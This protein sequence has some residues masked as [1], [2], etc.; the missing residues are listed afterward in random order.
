MKKGKFPYIRNTCNRYF[1][2]LPKSVTS[3][4]DAYTLLSGGCEKGYQCTE[5]KTGPTC[6]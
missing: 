4:C 5:S 2:E 3:G 6:M 1:S